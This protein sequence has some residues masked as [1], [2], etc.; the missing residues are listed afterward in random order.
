MYKETTIVVLIVCLLILILVVR[1][2]RQKIADWE[3][4]FYTAS[5]K[6][7]SLETALANAN[8]S[9]VS[10]SKKASSLEATASS[11]EATLRSVKDDFAWEITKANAFVKQKND[12]ITSLNGTIA[13]LNAELKTVVDQKKYFEEN[14]KAM[15]S[16]LTAFPY[17]A[18]IVADYE[19]YKYE[20]LAQKLNWGH[21]QQR[22]KKIESIRTIRSE[23]QRQIEEAK[24]AI[25]QLEYLKALYPQLNDVLEVDYTELKFKS[26]MPDYDPIRNYLSAEEWKSLS[27]SEKNQRALDNYVKSHRKTKWQIGR[28]YELYIGYIYEKKGYS[29]DYFGTFMGIEDLGRDLICKKGSKTYI[30]QCKYWSH[31]KK[32]HEKHIF[33]LYGTL[34]GYGIENHISMHTLTGVFCTN[35][36]LSDMAKKVAEYLK[37]EI[38]SEVEI[39]DFPRIKCNI[40]KDEY[41]ITK[42]YHLPMDQQYDNVKLVNRGEFFAMTVA[43][44]EAAGFRRAYKWHGV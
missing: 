2:L 12:L 17:M 9:I 20:I 26:E 43:E 16:N 19:T 21:N 31:D 10:A 29:V 28:D 6:A 39:Q 7:A 14:L 33:Q 18:G 38:H 27:D 24:E 40:G 5:N 1:H 34:V 22:E 3:S 30:V 13:A 44:A 35:I 41:G 4:E 36:E 37:I 25:Y 32:I 42:I 8:N 23:A 15:Q 11:L